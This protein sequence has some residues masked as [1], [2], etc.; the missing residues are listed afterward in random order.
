[1]KCPRCQQDNPPQA[2][3]CL[4]CG[5]SFKAPHESGPPA[6][7]S[8]DLQRALSDALEQQAA[9]S[10]ILRVISSSPTH[11]QP[12]FDAIARSAVRL[13]DARF[14]AVYR[15]DGELLHLAAHDN[16]SA[17]ALALLR[18]V[19]PRRPDEVSH[20]GRAVRE[21]DVVNLADVAGTGVAP[22]QS[23]RHIARLVGYRG[24]LAVPILR[25]GQAIGC[26]ALG[27]EKGAAFPEQQVLLVRTFADQAV[28]AIE[29]VRLFKELQASNRE[30]T[31]ALDKQTATSE[32]L[33]VISSAQ[34]DAQPVFETIVQSAG[35]LCNAAIAAVFRVEGGMVY[36]QANYGSA[37]DE[38][39]A[40]A[41]ARYPRPLGMDTVPGIAILTRST[42]HIP[43]VEDSG[44]PGHV[45]QV[46][47][48]LGF[49]S[50]VGLPMLREDKGVGAIVVARAELG[51]FSDGEVELLKTFA[52]QAVIAIENVRLF[53]ELAEKNRALTDAHVN[54]S[55][56]LERQTA[57]AEIL[58]VISSSPTDV[59]PVLDAVVESA[60]R[61][62]GAYDA[63]LWQ[64]E[65]DRLVRAAAAGPLL[66][67]SAAWLPLD[68]ELPSPRAFL[69]RRT[70]HFDVPAIV[71]THPER[72]PALQRLGL[73]SGLATLLLREGKP[74]GV[75]AVRR[76]EATRFSDEH[77]EL[78]Q[79]FADQA[80]IAIENVRLF[81]ELQERNRALTQA[82]A[83]VTEALEQQTA[84]SE[85]LRVI[86]SSPTDLQPVF[87]TIVENAAR[88][89]DARFTALF[90]FDG[91]LIT[92]AVQH[93]ST[94]EELAVTRA[95]FPAPATRGT[96]AGRAILERGVV[97]IHDIRTDL[98]YG[99]TA[100]L[101]ALGY[102]TALAVPMLREGN[103]IGVLL[104]WRREVSPFTDTQIELVKTFADQAVIAVENVR[105]FKELEA[106][107][108]ALTRSVGQLTALGEVSRALSST[109]DLE[110]VLNTIV[111]RASELAGTNA[112]TVYEYD[113]ATGEFHWRASAN[114]DE[115][116]EAVARRTTIP[117]GVGAQGRMAV[118]RAPVQIAD[119][120]VE[121]AYHGPLRDVLLQTGTRAILAVPLLRDDQLVGGLTVN[122]KTPGEFTPEVVNLLK[123]F[124]T[125][126]AL[127]IQ[128][129]RLFRE[130]EEKSRQLEAASQHKS[131]FLANM[132]HEL[133]T[134]LN[135]IIGFSELLSE[136]LY[137]DLNEKQ[138]EYLKDIHA[139]GQHLL[140]LINDILDLSKIEAGRMELEVT[141][142]DL[143]TAIDNAL[144]L[145]RERAGRRSIALHQAV[146][147]RLGQIRGD[148]RKI[149]QVL[150]NLLSN[151]IKFTP[152]GGEI[153]VRARGVDGP[154][155]VAVSDTGVGIASEDQEAIFEEFR[156]VG[157][158][159]KKVEGTGLGLA[160]SR[161]FIELHGGRIWVAS[162]VGVGSTFTF[163]LPVRHG[164]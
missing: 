157:T 9:T 55:E 160:V 97:H 110:T 135:A 65:G 94:P 22:P 11:V 99:A 71:A 62:C 16:F 106:R 129:A 70:I 27:R 87:S 109:L 127:A 147:E 154:V 163:T 19:F 15:F 146:D 153:D 33:R 124:A 32:I 75:L 91:E 35:R 1:M 40:A 143:P 84:T 54:I 102:R 12:V 113:D 158:A 8:V 114:P 122:R 30:L 95:V 111:A 82:H 43:D 53:N 104:N 59:Q 103:P 37:R 83:Q 139:S 2:K 66:E 159:A 150:L 73:K 92:V 51:S 123:T 105:L 108:A 79:T 20:V 3:F 23:H 86:S 125:Q 115:E 121:G 107:T 60:V 119:I 134:P 26:I 58:R 133:R 69:E 162:Q 85:I 6:A 18:T 72:V 21:R 29:N 140:S 39:L 47:H 50:L 138:E 96:A 93:G 61:L 130:I 76:Q 63:R 64:L 10:E 57:T 24:F 74:I 17:E 49:R 31:T 52:D 7:S 131:E 132:S 41:R 118:T 117:R 48:L 120:A 142:F 136:R 144:T 101:E 90:R 45:R 116:V 151:A 141:D 148:E 68:P 78:L 164:E 155:E 34:T 80:V 81:T 42:V 112:C 128:N 14:C 152:D 13:C 149:K 77:V 28:I 88:L 46:G 44:V 161:K 156:Q 4:E 145:V 89:C 126:S 56:A 67:E 38:L 100:A 5:T 36:H 137:G 25:E 98:E